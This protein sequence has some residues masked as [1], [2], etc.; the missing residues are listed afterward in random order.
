MYQLYPYSFIKSTTLAYLYDTIMLQS[1]HRVTVHVII[2][3]SP[4]SVQFCTFL[5]KL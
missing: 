3:L 5:T 2:K 1:V 4:F